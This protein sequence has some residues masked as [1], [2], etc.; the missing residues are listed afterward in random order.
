MPTTVTLARHADVVGLLNDERF[1]V[2]PMPPAGSEVDMRWLRASVSRFSVGDVHARRRRLCQDDLDRIDPAELRGRAA[3]LAKTRPIEQ[4]AVEVLA[5]ALGMKTSV[6]E[7]VAAVAAGYLPGTDAGHRGDDAVRDLVNAFGGVPDEATAARIALL[8]QACNATAALIVKAHIA[9]QQHASPTETVAE[10]LRF[11]P[12]V[13][14]MRRA[15]V[16]SA[17]IG[18]QAFEPGDTVVLDVKAANRD[19]DVFED[20]DRFHPGQPGEHLT[21]GAGLRPCPGREHAVAIA[22]GALETLTGGDLA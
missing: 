9:Q 2:P 20:P 22:V 21:F 12:P 6:Y 11:D 14:V 7:S 13:P 18:A 17:Q 4:I 15:C 5:D 1:Q 10:T 16:A 19:P 8:V 3:E